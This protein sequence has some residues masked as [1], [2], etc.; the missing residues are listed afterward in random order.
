MTAPRCRYCSAVLSH[1]LI[2][3]G[4]TPLANSYLPGPEAIISERRFP[5]KVMVCGDCLLAQVTTDVPADAIFDAGYAYFSS[6][7]SSWVAHAARYCADMINR[8]DL[9]P[10]TSFVLEAASNDGYLLQHFVERSFRCLGV[11]PAANCADAARQKGVNTEVAFFNAE[12]AR[13]IV[14]RHGRADLTAANNVLAH[15]PDIAGFVAGFSE[16]L[17]PEGVSTFEF[18]HLLNLIEKVQFDTIYHEHYSYLSLKAVERIF[19]E[20]G[21]TVIDVE[22]LPT[23]GG[24]LRVHAARSDSQR[25]TSQGDNVVRLRAAEERA[26]LDSLSGYAGFQDRAGAVRNAFLDALSD[27]RGE[28]KTI[29]AFGAAAKGNTFLNYCDVGTDAITFAVDSNPA[30]QGT[31]LP[32]SHIEVLDP[33]AIAT[34]KP[35]IVLILPWN[36]ADEIAGNHGYIGDWGGRFMV[37]VPEP[38]FL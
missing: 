34:R 35:D 26:G 37:A 16:V 1:T 9:R 7:S 11:E 14:A 19:K 27:L 6:Y 17:S 29:A 30:K 8:Y 15:V 12:T 25:A 31:L 10:E 13:D 38:R 4:E 28:G 22:E 33:E 20:Q 18:P 5:L 2:D 36:I 32:G 23:H 3:L 21:L 24:S